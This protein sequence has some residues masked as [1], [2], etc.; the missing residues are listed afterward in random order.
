M[1]AAHPDDETLG[2]GGLLAAAEASGVTVTV[3]VATDGDASHPRS[4]THSARDLASAR[5]REVYAALAVLAPSADVQLLG[6]PD[7]RVLHHLD[8]LVEQLQPIL[9]DCTHVVTPWA[10]DGHPDHEACS[11]A[12]ARALPPGAVHWQFPIWAWHW[13]DPGGDEPPRSALRRVHVDAACAEAKAQAISCYASQIQPLSDQPGDEAVLSPGMLEH[14]RGD[15]VFL[16]G[17]DAGSAAYF[18]DLYAR[19]ADP[20]GLAD[21]FYEQRKRATILAALTRPRFRRA[22]EPGCATGLLTVE[23][24]RRSDEVVAWDIAATAVDLSRAR[25]GALGATP[26]TVQVEQ[27]RIPVEWP[28]GTF[29]LIVLSEVGYYCPDLSQLVRRIDES[30]SEDGVLLACHWRHGEP[31]HPYTA[32]AVH[33]ALGAGRTALVSHVE[34]DFLLHVW[35]RSGRSVAAVEGIPGADD[36][37]A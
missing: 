20:W 37:P 36:G 1:L 19:N 10:E 8:D 27:G 4:S 11:R 32:G 21:R 30:L 9:K 25:V 2:A 17:P 35:S 23:L 16:V 34:E 15:E 3:V 6:L 5:R 22:F 31:H 29:D 24:G 28:D 33:G 12:A 18:E 7:G 13:A 14:F 26:S